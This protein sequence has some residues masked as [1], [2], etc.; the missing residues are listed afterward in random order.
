MIFFITNEPQHLKRY[1]KKCYDNIEVLEDNSQ[2]LILFKDFLYDNT[3]SVR[4]LIGYDVESNGLDAYK[5]RTIL[6]I[7]GNDEHQFILHSPYADS[8]SYLKLIMDLDYTF[9]G[10]NIKF[11][12]K[13]AKVEDNLT[14][15]KVYD[16]ML[17]EQRLYMKS[18]LS[19]SLENLCTRYLDVYPN[20]MD[21]SIRNTFIDIDVH[22]FKVEPKHLYYGAS[23]II[24]LYPIKEKQEVLMERYNI[25]YLVY[26]I[27]FPLIP[28]IAKAE[29]TGFEFN[30]EQW[31]EIYN[32]NLTKRFEVECALDIEVRK[33]RDATF[34]LSDDKRIFMIGGKWDNIRKYN[35]ENDLFNEDGTT[36]V[37]DLFGE[38]MS[39]QTFTG[40]KKKVELAPNNINYGSETQLMEIFG[41]LEEPLLTKEDVLVI[42]NFT[43]TQR[44]DKDH[45]SFQ[46]GADIFHTYLSYLPDT[47]MRPFIEEL[48]V[49]RGLNT[50]CNNFG[51]NFI[52]KL[53]PIT[54][55]L[56]TAFR[57]CFADT[58][59]FQSGGGKLEP[60]KP[61]FQNIPSKADY[62]IRMRNCFLSKKGYSIGTHDLSGAELIIMCSLSQDMKL[63]ETA[64]G[65]MHS[66]VAESCWRRIYRHRAHQ[67]IKRHDELRYRYGIE[68][69]DLALIEEI[70][71]N[72]RLSNTYIVD[73]TCKKVRTAFKPMTFGV[74]YGMYAGKASKTLNIS[75]EEGQIVID[76]IRGEFPDVFKMVEAASEFARANG[77]L[78]LNERTN[79]RAWFPN[80]I[81]LLRGDLDEKTGYKLIAKEMSEARNMKIQGT[82]ADMIKEATVDLQKWIDDNGLTNEITILSWVHDEIVDE[83]PDYLNGKSDEWVEWNKTGY[84]KFINDKGKQV[85]VNSFPEIKKLIMI[86]TCNR[87]LHNVTMNVDYDVEKF[88]TK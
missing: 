66:Y 38:S 54:G 32:E 31:L 1:R 13:F 77:Y 68:Y 15:T 72:I 85:N 23:D 83:H 9:I 35:P 53:N 78:I 55:R 37:L 51:A 44:V 74:I 50:A 76:F 52:A 48:L 59:R 43:K 4:K 57:Q 79:S 18:G 45:H 62:A 24:H 16:T 39:K 25:T 88:W 34:K 71:V 12:I 11:D 80:I 28:I 75:K 69:K 84:L 36:N 86:E 70:N 56:H 17:A 63:L 41:R 29:L 21:K 49:H 30:K 60:D 82:Q 2:T 42:P 14:I 20:A 26:N 73:K 8:Y 3:N 81:R 64:K 27:E 40:L 10:H 58:G 87:Y 6:K 47:R 7:I 33:L 67:L 5:N 22:K 61:N 65:D 19:M 46:T